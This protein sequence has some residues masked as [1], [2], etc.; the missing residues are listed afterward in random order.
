MNSGEVNSVEVNSV[1]GG[2]L[3]GITNQL[4]N[5]LTDLRQL[6]FAIFSIN[7]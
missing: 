2:V 3:N 1:K 5:R 7:L 4:I 6:I